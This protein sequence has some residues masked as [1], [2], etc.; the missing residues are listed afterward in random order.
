MQYNGWTTYEAFRWLEPYLT[1]DLRDGAEVESTEVK[2]A[3]NNMRAAA[4]S[5]ACSQDDALDRIACHEIAE[6]IT[7]KNRRAGR[8]A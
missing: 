6:H 1:E 4:R 7:E 8:R 3:L 5:A 2:D